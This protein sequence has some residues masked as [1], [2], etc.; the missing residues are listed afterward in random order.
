M[1]ECLSEPQ[2]IIVL[3]EHGTSVLSGIQSPSQTP[4]GDIS[5]TVTTMKDSHTKKVGSMLP[6]SAGASYRINKA[7]YRRT[8]QPSISKQPIDQKGE[9]EP[10]PLSTITSFDQQVRTPEPITV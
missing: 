5:K 8:I 6:V 3:S 2:K 1:G 9:I 10:G 4:I 7:R